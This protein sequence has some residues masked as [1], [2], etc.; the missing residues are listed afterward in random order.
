MGHDL[1][2]KWG[3]GRAAGRRH[4]VNL[5]KGAAGPE[6]LPAAGQQGLLRLVLGRGE[7]WARLPDALARLVLSRGCGRGEQLVPSSLRPRAA[8]PAPGA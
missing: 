4:G 6:P 7:Q 2:P 1:G 8:G 5:A 3:P